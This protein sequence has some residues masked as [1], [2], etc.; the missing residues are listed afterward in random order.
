MQL[1]RVAVSSGRRDIYYNRLGWLGVKNQLSSISPSGKKTTPEGIGVFF[2]LCL[3]ASTLR[4]RN[5][6]YLI[7]AFITEL[8]P[9]LHFDETASATN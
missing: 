2:C 9:L 4:G 8:F 3:R 5:C 6:Y 1:G 7:P